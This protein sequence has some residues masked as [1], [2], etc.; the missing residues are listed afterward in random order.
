MKI[1]GSKGFLSQLGNLTEQGMVFKSRTEGLNSQ[2]ENYQNIKGKEGIETA[3]KGFESM[4]LYQ[5]LQEMQKTVPE[6]ELFGEN[7]G[8]DVFMSLFYEKIADKMADRGTLGIGK[9][10]NEHLEK[11]YDKNTI[12]AEEIGKIEEKPVEIEKIRSEPTPLPKTI[13]GRIGNY[14]NIIEEA[15]IE[16]KLDPDLIRAV[17]VKESSGNPDAVSKVGAKGLMQLM[18]QTAGDLNVNNVFD[19]RENILAGTKYLKKQLVDNGGDLER[20]LAAYNAGPSVVKLYDGVPPY[21]ETQNY[22]E[23]VINLRYKFRI[24]ENI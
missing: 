2:L 10:L 19:P 3:A 9:M 21:K 22:I 23:D 13:S 11:K 7:Y 18:D 17:I 1:D 14:N 16:Y 15:A 4:F 8:E 12:P 6:S 20:A 5:M 24:G